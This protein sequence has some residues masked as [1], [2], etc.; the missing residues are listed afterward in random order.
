VVTIGG[1]A[2]TVSFSGLA[3]GNVGLYQVNVQ[4]PAGVTAGA[5]V[6]VMMTINGQQANVVTI[7]VDAGV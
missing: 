3:P 7:A 1:V 2:A 6:P 5:R 4:V